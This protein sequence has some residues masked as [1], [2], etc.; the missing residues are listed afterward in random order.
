V[1]ELIEKHNEGHRLTKNNR[2]RLRRSLVARSD[3][4][5]AEVRD[6]KVEEVVECLQYVTLMEH[7]TNGH[8]V[9]AVGDDLPDEFEGKPVAELSE[10]EWVRYCEANDIQLD[11]S[12]KRMLLARADDDWGGAV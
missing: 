3:F 5:P 11:P 7:R 10:S 9:V 2:K 8:G 12:S 1:Q 4:S 6:M